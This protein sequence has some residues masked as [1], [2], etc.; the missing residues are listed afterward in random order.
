MSL[1]LQDIYLSTKNKYHLELLT[2]QSS[3]K[4]VMNWVYIGEDMTT[5]DYLSGGELV[6]TTGVCI[7]NSQELLNFVSL[8]MVHEPCGLI[9][10]TGQYIHDTDITD[11]VVELCELHHFAIF[12]MPWKIP[13]QEITRD[14]YNRLFHDSQTDNTLTE[15]FLSILRSDRDHDSSILV[16]DD[17]GFTSIEPYCVCV[18]RYSSPLDETASSK[19][20]EWTKQL[21]YFVDSLLHDDSLKHHITIYKNTIIFI[22]CEPDLTMIDSTM[23]KIFTQLRIFRP[24]FD[25]HIGIGS[26]IFGLND[27]PVS[28][29]R[30]NAALT[31]A[32]YHNIPVSSFENMGFFKLLLS[33][34]DTALLHSY[35]ND[36]L[37]KLIE[38]DKTHGSSY[39]ET[40]HQYLL[41]NGSIQAIAT[42]MYC[43]RNTVNY[44]VRNLKEILDC[45]LD[46]MQVRFDYMTAFCIKDYLEIL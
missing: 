34:H 38:Y 39:L 17:F 43:H 22:C 21:L 32:E 8:L 26:V 25:C 36:H 31:I 37:G 11:A 28:Y 20:E 12:T 14:Y 27:L 9:I 1:T 30:A 4:K 29:K 46:D 33:V 45:N 2:S 16:L 5:F 3:L 41:L 44:R 19:S 10:N 40:L 24:H 35:L 6:I 13:F 7:H 23:N 18:L 42:A 15:A